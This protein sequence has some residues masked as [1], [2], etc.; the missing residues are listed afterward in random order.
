MANIFVS[1]MRRLLAAMAMA[2]AV[3]CLWLCGSF[4]KRTRGFAGKTDSL[5]AAEERVLRGKFAD[6]DEHQGVL[7]GTPIRKLVQM[8]QSTSKS[9]H[10]IGLAFLRVSG[11]YSSILDALT[12]EQ[13]TVFLGLSVFSW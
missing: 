9:R 6:A 12:A 3:Y 5:R 11:M 4:S 13:R 8:D 10:V 7:E 2:E 1:G